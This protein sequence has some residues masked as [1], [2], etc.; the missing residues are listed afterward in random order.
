MYHWISRSVPDLFI[1]IDRLIGNPGRLACLVLVSDVPSFARTTYMAFLPPP[2]H[3]L[4]LRGCFSRFRWK[5]LFLADEILQCVRLYSPWFDR[6]TDR[7]TEPR[8]GGHFFPG[9]GA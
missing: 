7:L 8:E 1:D 4:F 9:T 6:P 5:E 2:R 3:S